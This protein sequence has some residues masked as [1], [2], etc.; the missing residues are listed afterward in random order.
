LKDIKQSGLGYNWSYKNRKGY[1]NTDGD[2]NV[3]EF[4]MF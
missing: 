2:G 3:A 1:C 4:K